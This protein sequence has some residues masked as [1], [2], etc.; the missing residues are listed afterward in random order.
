MHDLW[1][2]AEF[3]FEYTF[4]SKTA[5][6]LYFGSELHSQGFKLFVSLIIHITQ[7]NDFPSE[8]TKYYLLPFAVQTVQ[9]K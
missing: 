2:K 8:M 9:L 4:D 6:I 7:I 1:K 5:S 3:S